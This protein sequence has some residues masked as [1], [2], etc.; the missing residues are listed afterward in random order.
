MLHY[1][2]EQKT[3]KY[4]KGYGFFLLTNNLS[5]KYGKKIFG[6]LDTATQ[7]GLGT[8]KTSHKKA[9]HKKAEAIRE[10]I[11]DKVTDKIVT[12]KP[13]PEMLQK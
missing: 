1:F 6:Y 5:N 13:V 3:R 12:Q 7:T 10:M 9:V 11:G 2:I 8:A 4:V